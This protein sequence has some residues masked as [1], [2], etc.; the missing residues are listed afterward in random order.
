MGGGGKKGAGLGMCICMCVWGGR[1]ERSP[2]GQENEQKYT[3]VQSGGWG[4][5]WGK[6]R[7]KH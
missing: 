5:E 3:V 2:E 1:Q 7:G 4:G 6:G